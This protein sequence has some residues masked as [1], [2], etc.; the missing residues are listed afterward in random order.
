MTKIFSYKNRPMHF[1]PY[2]LEKLK[3]TATASGM[4]DIP[5]PESLSFRTDDPL[6]IVNAMQEYQAMLDAT[7]DGLVKRELAEIPSDPQERANHLKA[8]GYYCDAAMVGVAEIPASAWLDEPL[9][10]P[11][12]ARLAGKI[13]TMQPKTLAAGIDVIMAGLKESMRAP[14]QDCRH[15][16]HALVFLYDH[17]RP[18]REDEPGADWILDAEAQRGCLRAMETAVTLSNYIRLLGYEARA[19]S[20]AAS[21]VHLTRLAAAS[22]LAAVEGGAAISPFVGP[23]FSVAVITTTLELAPDQPIVPGQRP[24]ASYRTGFGNHAKSARTRDPFARRDYVNGPHPFET[25]KRVDTPTTY[26]D[27]ANVARV[28]KRANM[29]ARSLFGDLG[30]AAQEAAKNGNYVR[31]SAAAFAF[32][33]SLGAFILLQDGEAGPIHPRPQTRRAMPPISRPRSIIWASMPSGFRLVPT[34]PTTRTTPLAN[35]LILTTKTR[36]P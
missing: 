27:A 31:K 34:G 12:V 29:F 20:A 30:P 22:G 35:P 5:P 2:P 13:Q 6:S 17:P 4:D 33:P 15:H 36:F 1:G 11:D 16:T 25:L 3:R 26:I 14:P 24:P 9:Q 8:F 23:D 7:R 28:P 19:H 10:N 32:R 21:N 18:P